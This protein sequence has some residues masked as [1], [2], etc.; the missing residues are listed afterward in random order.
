MDVWNEYIDSG[1]LGV[2]RPFCEVMEGVLDFL[3]DGPGKVAA[4]SKS[5]I[6]RRVSRL[7]QKANS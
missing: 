2:T 1:V 4:T 7:S 6:S 3:P 5:H